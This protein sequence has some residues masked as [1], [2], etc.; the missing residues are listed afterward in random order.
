MCLWFDK[1]KNFISIIEFDCNNLFQ[2][3]TYKKID[4]KN[5]FE[6]KGK[7]HSGNFAISKL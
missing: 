4:S 3:S 5:S 2:A 1:E 7:T 6:M